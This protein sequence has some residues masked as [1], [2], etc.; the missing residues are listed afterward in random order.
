[1]DRTANGV[2]VGN[3][4]NYQVMTTLAKRVGGPVL[5]G[6]VTLGTGYFVGKTAEVGGKRGFSALMNAIRKR[7]A[8][9]PVKNEVFVVRTDGTDD[10]GLEFR[11][12]A[13]YRVLECSDD[14]ILVELVGSD[15]NPHVVSDAFLATISDFPNG[16]TIEHD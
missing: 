15:D 7:S 6:L 4:G 2:T 14:A 10:Q 5:L 11:T 3:L 1:M 16:P 12:G 9:C 8:P 13:E